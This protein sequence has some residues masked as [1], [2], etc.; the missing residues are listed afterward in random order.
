MSF[1]TDWNE[2]IPPGNVLES[3]NKNARKPAS[4]RPTH[5]VIHVT[6]TNSLD[7]VKATFLAAN[8]VSAHYLVTP[9]GELYQ[10]VKDG[11]RAYHA[12][13]DTNTRKL[14]RKGYETWS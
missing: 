11:G 9:S 2:V 7:S 13:I 12:G 1:L 10:F 4:A 8:S 14:Y 5:I 6:G 3:P